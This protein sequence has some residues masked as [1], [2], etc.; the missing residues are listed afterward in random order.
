MNT[1]GKKIGFGFASIGMVLFVTVFFTLVQVSTLIDS[2]TEIR[3]LVKPSIQAN[4]NLLNGLNRS[5][6][7]LQEY[8]LFEDEKYDL[9]RKNTWE[10]IT[11]N[12]RELIEISP[13]WTDENDVRLLYLVEEEL[14]KVKIIQD[15]IVSSLLKDNNEKVTRLFIEE[16]FPRSLKIHSVLE[17]IL[18]RHH[19]Q[20]SEV[21][22]EADDRKDYLRNASTF[23]LF[24]GIIVSAVVGVL[25]T[26]VVTAPIIS[27]IEVARKISEGDYSVDVAI[28][29]SEEIDTLN[30]TLNHMIETLQTI[31]AAANRIASGDYRSEIL[32]QNSKDKLGMALH[33]MK[34]QLREKCESE[35]S[36]FA[37]S[38][39]IRGIE[40]MEQFS[41]VV[42]NHMIEELDGIAG[43]LY[44]VDSE[45]IKL[46][47][48]Y[49]YD[50]WP[51]YIKEFKVG[52]NFVGKC[53]HENRIVTMKD[54]P[55]D[56]R[57]VG[58]GVG[59]IRPSRITFFPIHF[60]GKINGVLELAS[61]KPYT[62]GQLQ[63]INASIETI[64]GSL[65]NIES[66][67]QLQSTLQ[68]TQRQ[69]IEL[70]VA[71]EN[72]EKQ[73]DVLRLSEEKLRTI[74]EELVEKTQILQAQKLKVEISRADLEQKSDEIELASKYKS[75]FLANMSHELRTPLNSL[76]LLS[77]N[78]S[79]N[80][81]GNLLEGQIEDLNMIHDG[82]D[83]LLNLINDIMDLSKVEA[84]KMD[85]LIEEIELVEVGA[86][87][88]GVFRPVAAKKNLRFEVIIDSDVP[89]T[90]N[91]DSQ[92]LEQIL[93]N[94][95][96]NALKFT[97]KGSVQLKIHFPK[98]KCLFQNKAFTPR[99]TLAFSVI[100]SGIGIPKEKQNE[101]FEAFQQKDGTTCRKYGG[102]GLGLTI[103]RSLAILLGGEIHLESTEG[104]SS[105]FTLYLPINEN[106]ALDGKSL[107]QVLINFDASEVANVCDY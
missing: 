55:A 98:E 105:T 76:L 86:S 79:K 29:G 11:A 56:Y 75:E 41:R 32:P 30:S 83:D 58:L 78:L 103:S 63:L 24:V 5:I 46:L 6:F 44:L 54:V 81:N 40:D 53:V 47:C 7:N 35:A 95:V 66:R 43:A 99:T 74:N 39:S 2:S 87:I 59:K 48:L 65:K 28:R 91:T 89:K 38:K 73:T 82:G 8:E 72:M 3:E 36:L 10:A 77:E 25:V 51:E 12:F 97:E 17:A 21:L 104:E 4:Q 71:N 96:S 88:S 80:W 34:V 102:T 50:E 15:E 90:L 70:R 33:K 49:A 62:E 20:L 23:L 69:Q 68:K 106:L 1:L 57:L 101:I 16:L 52:K 37:L 19:Q 85:L 22:I 61:M 100:D 94:F 18:E 60:H 93:K 67:D 107:G 14:E 45:T 26:R 64:G 42:L 13:N 31:V 9:D 27:S 84:G 92:R